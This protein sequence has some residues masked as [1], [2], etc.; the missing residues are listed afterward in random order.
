MI[1]VE[2]DVPAG[3]DLR[4][5]EGLVQRV[6]RTRGL[7]MK[8]KSSLVSYPGSTHWHFSKGIERGTL[9][10]TFWKRERRLWLSVHA[11]RTGAWTTEEIGKV[12]SAL[13]AQLRGAP[14]MPRTALRRP[15]S[16]TPER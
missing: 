10:V 7:D 9:E 6:C 1:A 11:N 13:E 3:A 15:A 2:V 12:K 5:V 8:V 4:R 16:P 14:Q